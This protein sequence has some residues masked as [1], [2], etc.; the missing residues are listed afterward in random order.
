MSKE[1]ESIKRKK[2]KKKIE[3]Q[4]VG[5]FIYSFILFIRAFS[6]SPTIN[7]APSVPLVKRVERKQSRG[8]RH[9]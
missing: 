7:V 4:S 8:S 2:K 5:L 9:I 1:E 3:N 6:K